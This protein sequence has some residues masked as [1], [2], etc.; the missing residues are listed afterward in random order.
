M[1]NWLTLSDGKKYRAVDGDTLADEAG[2]RFRIGGIDTFEVD[3][4]TD[5]GKGGSNSG[6][7]QRQN[8][9]S[10]IQNR[11]YSNINFSGESD[12][13]R[14]DGKSRE[15]I[16][17]DNNKGNDLVNT[18]YYQGL[19]PLRGSNLTREG[20]E[21]YEQGLLNRI[22]NKNSDKKDPYYDSLRE[23][24][25]I[26]SL[27]DSKFIKEP[28]INE[29]YFAAAPDRYKGTMLRHGDRDIYNQA[30]NSFV[31][32][33][34]GGLDGMQAGFYGV[35]DMTGHK[36]GNDDMRAI[37]EAGVMHNQAQQN[38]LPYWVQDVKEIDSAKKA[39]QWA[40][41]ALGGSLPYF[42]L[43]A[44]GMIPG[45]RMVTRPAM[46]LMYAGQTWNDMEGD[47]D[48]KSMTVALGAGYLQAWFEALG[49]RVVFGATSS[50]RM[51]SSKKGIRKAIEKLSKQQRNPTTGKF[52]KKSISNQQAKDLL[53][54]AKEYELVQVLKTFNEN[55]AVWAAYTSIVRDKALSGMV[56]EGLTE[57][58]QESTQMIGAWLGS[59]EGKKQ[60]DLKEF[61]DRILNATAAGALL[62]TG[63]R[64]G[65]AVLTTP[66]PYD[67]GVRQVAHD[68]LKN[69]YGKY[70]VTDPESRESV[71]YRASTKYVGNKDNNPYVPQEQ[72]FIKLKV[73]GKEIDVEVVG[74]T[75]E[76]G[77]PITVINPK[78]GRPILYKSYL[79]KIK[80]QTE[81]KENQTETKEDPN[82]KYKTVYDVAGGKHRVE[83]TKVDKNNKDN[84]KII[85]PN[86][87]KEIIGG[88]EF[89]TDNPLSKN[90]LMRSMLDSNDK[91]IKIKDLSDEQLLDYHKDYPRLSKAQQG[92]NGAM[93]LADTKRNLV[94]VQEELK[95]RGLDESFED[96][97]I[98][99]GKKGL[100]EDDAQQERKE[101]VENAEQKER[102]K[103]FDSAEKLQRK[104]QNIY[105][106]KKKQ[107]D[108]NIENTQE[109]NI[110]L[111]SLEGIW[112]FS[113]YK[114][115][116]AKLIYLAYLGEDTTADNVKESGSALREQEKNYDSLVAL[117]NNPL[118]FRINEDLGKKPTNKVTP[119][120][121]A[122]YRKVEF[123]GQADGLKLGFNQLQALTEQNYKN[124]N[125]DT[126]VEQEEEI[127][128]EETG[129]EQFSPKKNS[130]ATKGWVQSYK[131]AQKAKSGFTRAWEYASEFR[132]LST[133]HQVL[134]DEFIREEGADAYQA[135]VT[136]RAELE[137]SGFTNRT[138]THGKTFVQNRRDIEGGF[139]AAL[140]SILENFMKTIP[141]LK[142]NRKKH[143]AIA[144]E[145][146]VNNLD[147]RGFGPWQKIVSESGS[148][149][150]VIPP[151]Y[152][153]VKGIEEAYDIALSAIIAYEAV[154]ETTIK[155]VNSNYSAPAFHT[156]TQRK[157]S[158]NKVIEGKEK[159]I[160]LLMQ[161]NAVYLNSNVPSGANKA[162]L[163]SVKMTRA[164]AE[165][166]YDALSGAPS[167]YDYQDWAD[168]ELLTKKPIGLKRRISF[169]NPVFK[170][171]LE[172]NSYT[173]AKHRATEIAHYVSDMEAF[174]FGG[175][176][177]HSRIQA[178]YYE[179]QDYYITKGNTKEQAKVLADRW[180]PRISDR[181]FNQ[182]LA[183][184]GE[185]FK[186]KD[187][188]LRHLASNIGSML[189]LAFMGLATFASFAEGG[190]VFRNITGLNSED[191]RKFS[192]A[193]AKMALYTKQAA[194]AH[195]KKFVNLEGDWA[196]TD[197]RQKMFDLQVKR[198]LTTHDMGAGHVIDASYD[199]DQQNYLQ[200]EIMPRYYNIIGLTPL[201]TWMRILRD[202]AS[203]EEIGAYMQD[204]MPAFQVRKK[205]MT[206]G[207]PEEGIGPM[208]TE[209]A[210]EFHSGSDMTQKEARAWMAMTQLGG[211]PVEVLGLYDKLQSVYVDQYYEP[212][213]NQVSGRMRKK[214]RKAFGDTTLNPKTGEPFKFQMSD[215]R[216]HEW[217]E[218]QMLNDFSSL[219]REVPPT[220]EEKEL[221]VIVK[222]FMR[223]LDI[224]RNNFVD[225]SLVNPDPGKRPPV[226][227]DGRMRLLFLFQ[228]YLATFSAQIARPILRDLAGKGA[229]KDQV[230]AASV[231]L[232]MMALAFLGL[233]FKD[234]IK[235]GDR[236]AWL[237][238][239]QYIQR[240]IQ[241][242][243]IMGQTERVFNLMFP[244]YTSEADTIAD[245]A[246][247]EVGAL[248]GATESLFR[249]TS[250]L[251]DGDEELAYNQLLKLAPGGVLTRGRQNVSS[252]IAGED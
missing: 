67:V 35:L 144:Y 71:M 30:N 103:D 245:K 112:R 178:I 77:Q 74:M 122:L 143:R 172:T 115:L 202:T 66:N 37:G 95:R 26:A 223:H 94:A 33:L 136:L 39:F 175:Q 191:E 252:F 188:G 117:P 70:T 155:R 1:A 197:Y 48:K 226:Y 185:Y 174:G 31:S 81:T 79:K 101:T 133:G 139:H 126:S 163:D 105:L 76:K 193:T 7:A 156:L 152:R 171:F 218:Q 157:I 213:L 162:L 83:V 44:T 100:D 128:I 195:M 59:E 116:Q 34:S 137:T 251:M 196:N 6:E 240:G 167:G 2:N 84:Y 78:T 147:S 104:H 204:A 54:R 217:L 160:K 169:D 220:R 161:G 82:K 230:N 238:D 11:Q 106:K 221:D 102:K 131:D 168:T 150:Q 46:T 32:G 96:I 64:G 72:T 184:R 29:A 65:G 187:K 224:M 173:T 40:G 211:N 249:G 153:D 18:M 186:L 206:K 27:G 246:F 118:K 207:V 69:I 216:F 21:S 212:A 42:G 145:L 219:T 244:L 130:D 19:A 208:D 55:K 127:E 92:K 3:K 194:I 181:I 199:D 151:K 111:Q 158:K 170:P 203:I 228:G 75:D 113:Y 22:M 88:S 24:L 9:E 90:Y 176:A 166:E 87:G 15:I 99:A 57:G 154:K 132:W 63:I 45:V 149:K 14:D 13:R 200:R 225:A 141:G 189:S 179:L 89:A 124:N 98:N 237:S 159:F 229:P 61:G 107:H 20:Q 236:P 62:G 192:L 121:Y 214:A 210:A 209:E 182:Y 5:E 183:H 250:H 180:M 47:P 123:E 85:D 50:P 142:P 248:A 60:F 231:T 93:A 110:H 41:G 108:K 52:V 43:M 97:I 129:A 49:G 91:R 4:G 36:V 68:K 243:G 146:L 109:E 38:D 222:Q 198:G 51:L 23:N 114:A 58:A 205:L 17:L 16:S 135:M 201:T 165:R 235:Y 140:D 233:A 232:T 177:L 190:L 215:P 28:A 120:V 119:E 73:D 227:S 242:S 148:S 247:A 80:N 241:G 25:E 56:G 134:V 12:S 125:S 10:M 138:T 234:E 8:L 53:Y 164:Q 86:T 239:A